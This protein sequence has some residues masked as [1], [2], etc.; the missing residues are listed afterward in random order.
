MIQTNAVLTKVQAVAGVSD[1]E[2]AAEDGEE[3]WA[4]EEPVYY[5]EKRERRDTAE[6]TDVVMTRTLIVPNSLAV[7][8]EQQQTVTWTRADGQV[9][10]EQVQMVERADAPGAG[11]AVV[12]TT[13]VRLED[14]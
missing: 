6:G 8:F 9:F 1:Y 10:T 4:G 5:R 14:G 11:Y 3:V 7:V 13:R 2:R 12:A